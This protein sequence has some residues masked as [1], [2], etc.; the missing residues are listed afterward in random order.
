MKIGVLLYIARLSGMYNCTDNSYP[1]LSF[2]IVFGCIHTTGNMDIL[3]QQI[4]L[5]RL[6]KF[7]GGVDNKNC[8]VQDSSTFSAP[9]PYP[10]FLTLNVLP[11]VH[12]Y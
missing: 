11:E 5:A 7:L 4:L 6:C 2:S 9:D 8:I 10:K 12:E 3:G 1:I